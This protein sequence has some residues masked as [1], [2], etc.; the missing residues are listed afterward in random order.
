VSEETNVRLARAKIEMGEADAAIV[1]RTDAGPSQQ[2][3][4]VEIPRQLNVIADYATGVVSDTPR[5]AVAEAWIALVTSAEG[6]SILERHG[7]TLP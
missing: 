5:R 7:F 2:V 4:V 6:R 3:R 1:Y